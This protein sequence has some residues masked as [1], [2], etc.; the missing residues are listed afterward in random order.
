M[1]IR[2]IAIVLLAA[3]GAA[4]AGGW[5]LG[6]GGSDATAAWTTATVD[7]GTVSAKVTA[8]GTFSALVTVTVGSQVSGRIQELHADYNDQVRKGQVLARIDPLLFEAAVAQAN[9]SLA[10]AQADV[11]KARAQVDDARRVLR[12]QQV[13]LDQRIVTQA[14][15]DTALTTAAVA[16]AVQLAAEAKVQ[17]AQ[18]SLDQARANL[19][20]TT[21]LSPIDGMVISRSVDVGQTVAASLQ[22]PTLFTIAEDLRKMQV[23]TNVAEADVGRIR[24]G[25]A[26]KVRVD[27]F[28]DEPFTGS[29]R[30]VRNAA[31]TVSNVVTYDAVI[32][33]ANPELRLRPGM[34]A[35]VTFTVAEAVDA[36]R[37][38]NAALRFRPPGAARPAAGPA[39]AAAVAGP[40][41]MPDPAAAATQAAADRPHGDGDRPWRKKRQGEGGERPPRAKRSVQV[42]RGDV[43]QAVEVV[44]G[45]TD[46]AFTEIVAGALQAG[47]LVVTGTAGAT[48]AK[49][50]AGTGGRPPGPF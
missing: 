6:R 4:A 8:S 19:L 37:V 46:G 45:A 41:A 30:Q 31:Q 40:S 12:R 2:T 35:T 14:D 43:L 21:I 28:P 23:D 50:P 18:A 32:D 9:A 25:M 44:T 10:A 16:D 33:V 38:P 20:Y 39:S 11:A 5:W 42:L 13:L 17:Q 3:G 24:T 27:A 29:V 49:R 1:R 7:R 47:D 22:A 34:T 48:A 26:A 15:L 36:L